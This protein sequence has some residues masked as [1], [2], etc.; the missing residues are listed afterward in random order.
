VFSR[1]PPVALEIAD[2]VRRCQQGIKLLHA[3]N[4][5]VEAVAEEVFHGR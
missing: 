5:S 1:E 4:V 3:Q 2:Y